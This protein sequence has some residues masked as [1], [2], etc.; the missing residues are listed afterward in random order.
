VTLKIFP[1][2]ALP[3][4]DSYCTDSLILGRCQL[5]EEKRCTSP[6]PD[7]RSWQ[8]RHAATSSQRNQMVTERGKV[9]HPLERTVV[10]VYR[11]NG[12]WSSVSGSAFCVNAEIIPS[13]ATS[14]RDG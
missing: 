10:A 9:I 2:V 14:D 1:P 13:L 3:L 5:K 8:S 6:P 7:V 4:F 12:M 11:Q